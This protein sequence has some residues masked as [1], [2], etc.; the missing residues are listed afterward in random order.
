MSEENDSA[1]N[2]QQLRLDS[3]L[4]FF[5][6]SLCSGCVS[7]VCCDVTVSCTVG[8]H[9]LRLRQAELREGRAT[10]S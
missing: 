7:N 5:C 1:M 3:K 10:M 8:K 9:K 6:Y 2:A 4:F